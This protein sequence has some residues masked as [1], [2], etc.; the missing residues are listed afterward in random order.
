VTAADQGQP[1]GL[2]HVGEEPGDELLVVEERHQVGAHVTGDRGEAGP[3]RGGLAERADHAGRLLDR[4]DAL[5]SDVADQEP[6]VRV[7]VVAVVEVAA[8]EG[9]LGR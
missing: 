9:V 1:I 4:G 3:R 6:R 2:G 7:R 5:A 8:H